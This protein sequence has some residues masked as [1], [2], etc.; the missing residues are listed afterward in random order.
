MQRIGCLFID[1][2]SGEEVNL[3]RDRLGRHWMVTNRWAL[4]RI[5]RPTP[6]AQE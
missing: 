4:F 1:N 2:I 5:A 6:A 3:Y